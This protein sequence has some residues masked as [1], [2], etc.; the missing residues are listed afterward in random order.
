M[1]SVPLLLRRIFAQLQMFHVTVGRPFR[2]K[3]DRIVKEGAIERTVE[4]LLRDRE[5]VGGIL[6][7]L[8]A[9]DDCPAEL[10]PE[11]LRRCKQVTGLPVAVVIANKEFEA[12]FLGAKESLAGTRGVVANAV[13]PQNPEDIRGARERLSQNMRGRRCVSVDDQPAFAVQFD[14]NLARDRCPSFDKLLRD[15]THLVRSF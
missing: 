3:R 2:V 11:L 12:W 10:G 8:D 13:A 5:N 15:V 1:D 6:V 4:Q 7:I 14:M 9:D